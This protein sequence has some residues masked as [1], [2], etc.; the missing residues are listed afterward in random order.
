M[1]KTVYILILYFTS[2]SIVYGQREIDSLLQLLNKTTDSAKVDLLNQ[3][4]WK[5]RNTNAVQAAKY[6]EEAIALARTLKYENGLTKA[7]SF[8]GVSYRNVGNHPKAMTYYFEGLKLAEQNHNKEYIGYFLNNIG[9]MYIYQEKEDE[10]L[11]YLLK[12]EKVAT[13]INHKDLIAYSALNIGRIYT[14]RQQYEL[15]L[16]YLNKSLDVRLALKKFDAAAVCKKYIADIYYKQ[17]LYDKAIIAYN[18]GYNYT[19]VL[20][21]DLDLLSDILNMIAKCKLKQGKSKD[22]IE[23]ALKSLSRAT[24]LGSFLR[25]QL[26]NETISEIYAELK[27]YS[28]AYAYRVEADKY[29][30]SLFNQEKNKQMAEMQAIYETEKKEQQIKIAKTE[31]SKQQT[32]KNA[33]IAGLVLVLGLVVIAYRSYRIKQRDNKTLQLQNTAIQQQKQEIELKNLALDTKNKEVEKQRD[34]I[35]EKNEEILASIHYAKKIQNAVLPSEEFISTVIPHH[36]I[37]FKPRDIVSGDFYWATTKGKKFV[38]TAADCTG[39]GVPGALMSMLGVSYLAE[40]VSKSHEIHA[41]DILN[42]LRNLIIKSLHQTGKEGENQDGM[43]MALIVMDREIMKM[44]FAGANNSVYLIRNNELSEYHADKMPIGIHTNH[45][46]SFTNHEID[47]QHDD[48]IYMCSD[49]YEDQFGGEK[50]KKYLV[51]RF[52]ELLVKIH[53]NPMKEQREIM[54][55]EI[56]NWIGSKYE[57]IDDILVIGIKV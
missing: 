4:C 44:E 41:S 30:D 13:E 21:N 28:K 49:G 1:K 7:L 40:I 19:I 33:L 29:R 50:G 54:D 36:F 25:I 11:E 53:Q 23:N 10:G 31:L 37:L 5:T 39:H 16:E 24:K 55:N 15:A 17:G 51:K 46:V 35:E 18:T 45:K 3:L 12:A 27:E 47:I 8:T 57:Q 20:D 6:G 34:T 43:D 22:A 32:E 26:A 56:K 52:K 14:H 38:I 42:Q 2:L 9:N 48:N